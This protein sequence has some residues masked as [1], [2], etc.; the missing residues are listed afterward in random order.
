MRRRAVH[1]GLRAELAAS[2]A[3]VAAVALGATFLAVYSGTASRLRAQLDSQ[4]RTQAA[5]W[6]QSTAGVNLSTPS[7][8]D[9]RRDGSSPTSATTPRP[10]SS[11]CRSTATARSPTIPR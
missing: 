11:R 1:P 3:L 5:E 9:K 4:L 2:I 8:L 6:R 10:R 7:A